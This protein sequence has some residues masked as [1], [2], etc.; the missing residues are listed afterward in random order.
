MREKYL[1]GI[2]LSLK[3]V[4]IEDK[5]LNIIRLN[6][7]KKFDQLLAFLF[8]NY[9]DETNWDKL[10]IEHY[11]AQSEKYFGYYDISK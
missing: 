8:E 5:G 2:N 1:D 4:H 9:E 3:V 7:M 10:A 11:K 6:Y